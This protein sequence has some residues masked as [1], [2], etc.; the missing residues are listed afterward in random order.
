[1]IPQKTISVTITSSI[2]LVT[3]KKTYEIFKNT[4]SQI[5]KNK[6]LLTTLTKKLQKFTIF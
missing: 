5:M 2:Q 4:W 6:L 3:T 1:M